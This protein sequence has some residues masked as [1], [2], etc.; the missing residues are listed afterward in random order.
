[1]LAHDAQ[2]L[3]DMLLLLKRSLEDL[4]KAVVH[5]ADEVTDNA[6]LSRDNLRQ[7]E[8]FFLF[9]RVSLLQLVVLVNHVHLLLLENS[10]HM[11]TF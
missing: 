1:M 6:L 9:Y 8:Y 5:E 7:F 10:H 4:I 3:N 11:L 2:R